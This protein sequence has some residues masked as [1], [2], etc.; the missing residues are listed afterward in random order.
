MKIKKIISDK[1]SIVYAESTSE[2]NNRMDAMY[3]NTLYINNERRLLNSS[4]MVRKL[5]D[6]ILK[7]NSPIGWQ[8]I[9]S[10]SYLDYG[11]G[12]PLIRVQNI[13]DLF[14]NQETLIGVQEHIYNEQPAIQSEHGDIVI[15]RVGDTIGKVCIVPGDID[16]IAMGQNLTRIKV[17][18][19][20]IDN[21]YLMIF[22]STQFAKLQMDQLS[23]GGA[24]PSLTNRNI[25][26]LKVS[27]PENDFQ[28]FIANKVLYA[29]RLRKEAQ[30]V[31]REYEQIIQ[32]IYNNSNVIKFPKSIFKVGRKELD[33]KYLRIDSNFYNPEYKA[34]INKSCTTKKL[35]KFAKLKKNCSNNLNTEYLYYEI[36]DL[37]NSKILEDK[38]RIIG[39]ELP[40]RAKLLLKQ[41]DIIV[42]LV[43]ESIEVTSFVD[44]AI[45]NALTTNGCAVLEVRDE[46]IA[47]YLYAVLS[48]KY[49]IAIKCKYISGTNIRSMSKEDLMDIDIPLPNN[50]TIGVI[51]NL[52][53]SEFYNLRKSKEIIEEVKREVE[54]FIEGRFDI[55]KL[56]QSTSGSR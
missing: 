29:E 32:S 44:K 37:S 56:K 17:D 1:P 39:S 52:V 45:P 22:L 24:Q 10:S 33:S 43:Q 31:K 50:E 47:P 46:K 4:V 48:S 51:S 34:D 8:G 53:I 5:G 11:E 18:E 19:S 6:I 21:R 55:S 12:V 40:G 16:K 27:V 35:S 38:G 7:M 14:L 30:K 28:K 13:N 3:Y 54:D 36:G 23:Y 25:R 9:P 20:I 49:F 15:T 26:E 41:N 42:S 2:F